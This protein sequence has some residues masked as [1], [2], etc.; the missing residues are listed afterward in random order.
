MGGLRRIFLKYRE[1]ISYVF[2]GGLTTLCNIFVY[3][4]LARIFSADELISTAIAFVISVIFAFY[5]NRKWV[6][7]SKEKGVRPVF[8]EGCKFF[9]SRLFSGGLDLLIM[10]IFVTILNYN[11]MIIKILSNILVIILNFIF[12]KLFVFKKK[13]E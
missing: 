1:L 13:A 6:F 12:S 7:F 3:W 2:F 4:V 8:F 5:T 9:A 11:D 10:F